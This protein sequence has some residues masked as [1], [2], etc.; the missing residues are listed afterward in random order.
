MSYSQHYLAPTWRQCFIYTLLIAL[1]LPVLTTQAA[2]EPSP[3]YDPAIMSNTGWD[4]LQLTSGEWLKGEFRGMENDVA[5]FDS[6]NLDLLEIDWEDVAQLYTRKPMQ[7]LFGDGSIA[8]GRLSHRSNQLFIS[9]PD[10]A[11]AYP[12][13]ISIAM[14]SPKELDLWRLNLSLGINFSSGNSE[15]QDGNLVFSSRRRT[16]ETTFS[17]RYIAN[18]GEVDGEENTNNQRA[19]SYFDYRIDNNW[20]MRPVSM[21]Y[22]RDPFQNI[23][24]QWTVGFGAVYQIF[25]DAT[26][27]WTV[28]AGPGYQRTR[29]T[30]VPEEDDQE[31]STGA[32]FFNTHLE[33]DI[34][35][36]IDLTINYQVYLVN[37][38]S[39]KAR[40]NAYA[41]LDIDLT[42][43]LDFKVGFYWDRTEEPQP[44]SNG[45]VP[46]KD[47]VRLTIGIDYEY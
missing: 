6:D 39:G 8:V 37:D 15:Q 17:F 28:S 29:Y 13:V 25:D 11:I 1:I 5:D 16:A 35:S 33:Q 30:E 9:G 18:Y 23:D 20:Y 31:V 14:G 41:G 34:T 19:T 27:Y 38:E 42:D 46:E 22:Y 2:E 24:S 43:S 40:H 44:D 21:E 45:V 36:D 10:Q 47:D 4:W 26:T 32:F 12:N 7:V 3:V